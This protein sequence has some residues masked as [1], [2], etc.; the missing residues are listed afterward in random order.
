MPVAFTDAADFSGITQQTSLKIAAVEHGADLKID[1]TGTVAAAATGIS[2]E[3][4]T[5]ASA[6]G[7]RTNYAWQSRAAR[8]S[9]GRGNDLEERR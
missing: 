7:C 9:I 2:L 8:A 5:E 6:E 4:R 1:E 3:L